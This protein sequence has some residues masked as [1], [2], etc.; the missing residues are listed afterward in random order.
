MKNGATKK[1]LLLLYSH[2]VI[3]LTFLLNS[4]SIWT[5]S[6]SSALRFQV[7]AFSHFS[8]LS[9]G[10][11]RSKPID[12]LG[13]HCSDMAEI[14]FDSVRVPKKN[15][16]GEEGRGFVYQMLQFQDV[17]LVAVAVCQFF[18]MCSSSKCCPL[19][20]LLLDL[21][22]IFIILNCSQSWRLDLS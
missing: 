20:L 7:S 12:K 15:I 1:Y 6:R 13:M 5:F 4:V 19:W 3:W 17:R 21:Y 18:F 16:I 2:K 9:S 11:H 22:A 8:L 14:C 10:I